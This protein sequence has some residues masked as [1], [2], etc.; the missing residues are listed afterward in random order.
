MKLLPQVPADKAQHF[1]YGA[2][3]AALSTLA[4]FLLARALRV[5]LP[6]APIAAAGVAALAG[7]AKEVMDAKANAKAAA[8]GEPPPHEVSSAD[9]RWTA[10]GGVVAA[11]PALLGSVL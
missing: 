10:I 2:V 8:E 1:I 9:I 4:L 11:A 6:L 3:I 7:K 5:P